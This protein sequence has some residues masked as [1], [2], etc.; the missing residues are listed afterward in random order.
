MRRVPQA[1]VASNSALTKPDTRAPPASARAKKA[2]ACA[3][4]SACSDLEQLS[5]A[6]RQMRPQSG[7]VLQQ[8]IERPIQPVLVDEVIA[9]SQQI[10][11]RRATIPV[12]GDMQFA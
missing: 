4:S 10:R 6:P 7:F 2:D 5:A 3:R 12:L 8:M 11:E 1:S 9:Q